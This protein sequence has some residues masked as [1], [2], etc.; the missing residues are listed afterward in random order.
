M[1]FFEDLQ[2]LGKILGIPNLYKSEAQ[3]FHLAWSIQL[4]IG[5]QYTERDR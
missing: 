3:C 5:L 1:A 4:A 2:R